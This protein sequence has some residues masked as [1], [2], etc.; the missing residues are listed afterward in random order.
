MAES[1]SEILIRRSLILAGFILA[2]A[3]RFALFSHRSPD[4]NGFVEPWY[5]ILRAEDFLTAF[6]KNF[7]NY[8]PP[9]LYLLW[10]TAKLDFTPIIGIKL[11]SVFFE[12]GC[13][14]LSV[15]ISG[16]FVTKSRELI[17]FVLLFCPSLILNASMWGQAEPVYAFFTLLAVY[18]AACN[19][20][21]LSLLC[22]GISFSFKLQAVFG[23]PAFFIL[24]VTGTLKFKDLRNGVL[25]FIAAYFLLIAPTWIAGRSFSDLIS[26][27]PR[28]SRTY[29]ALNLGAP[30]IWYWFR[31]DAFK[32][33]KIAGIYL[34][35]G[36]I[37]VWASIS[38]GR[39]IK[40][41]QLSKILAF[42]ISTLLVPF[43]LPMMHERYFYCADILS[44]IVAFIVPGSWWIA[45]CVNFSSWYAY[46][47]W[48]YGSRPFDY[49]LIPFFNFAALIGLLRIWL[50]NFEPQPLQ[51]ASDYRTE[52]EEI[53]ESVKSE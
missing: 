52:P 27:Y 7:Y 8:N 53:S 43:F 26:I 1:R 23:M 30:N 21:T 40:D 19:R 41:R 51:A 31:D 12:L 33:F 15:M 39:V 44:I 47:D 29:H 35:A 49:K 11:L 16:M 13:I 42:A 45:V 38:Y 22:M 5:K 28:Q 25:L 18:Y 9:Y 24:W 37:V 36:L 14:L 20:F 6:S 48:T 34:T 10:L 32:M 4:L 3:T 2:L 46:M 50:G 17:F